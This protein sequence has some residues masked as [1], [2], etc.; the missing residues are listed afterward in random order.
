MQDKS[1]ASQELDT[2]KAVQA[3]EARCCLPQGRAEQSTPES[4]RKIPP[5]MSLQCPLLTKLTI[6]Q[7]AKEKF[8]DDPLHFCRADNEDWIWSW[9]AIDWELAQSQLHMPIGGTMTD[10]AGATP[11]LVSHLC[12]E[13]NCIHKKRSSEHGQAGARKPAGHQAAFGISRGEKQAP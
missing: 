12:W 4:G 3:V 7:L 11:G 8:W 10:P 13:W 5:T 9:E 2:G 1:L 6:C